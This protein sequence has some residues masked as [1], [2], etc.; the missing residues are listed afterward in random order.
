MLSKV[1]TQELLEIYGVFYIF[2]NFF[3]FRF[4]IYI[5]ARRLLRGFVTF[6]AAWRAKR[7]ARF[8]LSED[9]V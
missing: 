6:L 4:S 3:G 2:F 8:Q 5:F 9:E 1:Y 7:N